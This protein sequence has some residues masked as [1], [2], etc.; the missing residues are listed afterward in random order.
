MAKE[1]NTSNENSN[2]E[3]TSS[4]T[5]S[6]RPNTTSSWETFNKS[7]KENNSKKDKSD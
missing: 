1:E 6:P 2:S 4:E 3:D 5:Q 7:E